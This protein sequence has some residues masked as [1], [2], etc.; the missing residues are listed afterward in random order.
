MRSR[1]RKDGHKMFRDMRRFKQ[2][3]SDME[4]RD[5]L[6]AGTVGTLGV[7]GDNDYPY[8][9][10]VHYVFLDDKIY[11]HCATAGHKIDALKR[12]NKVSFCVIGQDTVVPE[13]FTSFYRSVIAFGRARLLDQGDEYDKAIYAL[14]KKYSSNESEDRIMN[15]IN[16]SAGR[17]MMIAIDIEHLTGK[18]AIELVRQRADNNS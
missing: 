10:P 11:I 12:N 15:E 13:K 2:A 4:T 3:L 9:V 1:Y 16:G 7:F 8:T 17:L 14:A 6:E 5:I 18:E